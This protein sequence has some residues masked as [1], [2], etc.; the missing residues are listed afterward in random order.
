MYIVFVLEENY[1][2]EK[3]GDPSIFIVGWPF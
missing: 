2:K 3:N 1:I